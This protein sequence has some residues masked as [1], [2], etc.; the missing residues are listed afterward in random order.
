MG[1]AKARDLA[2]R[3]GVNITT[4]TADLATYSI[5]PGIWAGI[6]ATFVHLPAPVRAAIHRAAAAGLQ[7]GGV[8]ILE[9]YTPAQLRHRTG[10]PVNSPE[11]LMTLDALRPEFAG[12]DL[13]VAQEIERDVHEG[14]GHT[15]RGAVVQLLA[16]RP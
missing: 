13:V 5:A 12:L 2:S 6:V 8:V 4:V 16:R 1:L 3:R 7:P 9:A 14:T 11:L 15:G 10:G